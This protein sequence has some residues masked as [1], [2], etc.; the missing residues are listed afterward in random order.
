MSWSDEQPDFE[1]FLTASNNQSTATTDTLKF[2]VL[3]LSESKI[4]PTEKFHNAKL[5]EIIAFPDPKSNIENPVKNISFSDEGWFNGSVLHYKAECKSCGGD[6]HFHN[7]VYSEG[8]IVAAPYIY[9]VESSSTG[10]FIQQYE[11]VM[12]TYLNN[13]IQFQAMLPTNMPG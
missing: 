12:K 2:A 1:V 7:K 4:I 3:N 6:V 10:T 11:S 8:D 13:S 9:E 5:N